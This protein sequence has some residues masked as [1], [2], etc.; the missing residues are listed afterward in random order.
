MISL[1]QNTKIKYFNF[2]QIQHIII[3]LYQ[4]FFLKMGQEEQVLK[5]VYI[6]LILMLQKNLLVN[7]I[8]KFYNLV[9]INHMDFV[10]V[11][12]LITTDTVGFLVVN[13]TDQPRGML[14]GLIYIIFFQLHPIMIL[15]QVV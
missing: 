4:A 13:K 8:I 1:L 7:T 5:F 14:K 15:S 12:F 3:I 10:S 2:T 9:Q 6:I 11:I